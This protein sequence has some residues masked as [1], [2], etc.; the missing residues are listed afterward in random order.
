[1]ND[2]NYRDAA[3]KAIPENS[4]FSGQKTVILLYGTR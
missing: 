2:A 1:M 4:D 3:E